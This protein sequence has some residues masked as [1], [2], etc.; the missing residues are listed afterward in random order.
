MEK[1]YKHIIA[2]ISEAL[3]GYE[4]TDD[5]NIDPDLIGGKVDDIR[6]LL[7]RDTYVNN[8]L[9]GFFSQA[10]C[11]EI[12]CRNVACPVDAPIDSP[13]NEYYI[14]LP[15]GIPSLNGAIKYLGGLNYTDPFTWVSITGF[16]NTKGRRF[17][18]NK[19]FYTIVNNN[20][21]TEAKLLNPPT[22][23]AKYVCAFAAWN[24]PNLVCDWNEEE[25]YPVPADLI[26]KLEYLVI[27]H[28]VETMGLPRDILNDAADRLGVE[29]QKQDNGK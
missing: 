18:A 1:S 5:F 13:Y 12:Q 23:G 25:K 21:V 20:G 24:K 4:L 15:G 14:E 19:T 7:M 27:K 3:S 2:D 10:C 22:S 17:T 28:F 8:I 9:P 16:M 6:S 26:H 29:Q 11:L